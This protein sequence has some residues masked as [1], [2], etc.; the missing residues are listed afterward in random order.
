MNNYQIWTV[1]QIQ[2]RNANYWSEKGSNS[3]S[4]YIPYCILSDISVWKLHLL[5]LRIWC[6]YP[7]RGV[8]L[9]I[10][11]ASLSPLSSPIT[12]YILYHFTFHFSCIFSVS[13]FSFGLSLFFSSGFLFYF[14]R[15]IGWYPPFSSPGVFSC[16]HSI[17]FKYL[18]N[19][20]LKFT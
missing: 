17:L 11:R 16:I 12:S 15:V 3:S 7:S 10:P 19:N 13:S 4:Q 8:L 2:T 1:L 5:L 18:Q 20:S 6:R 14:L 9:F